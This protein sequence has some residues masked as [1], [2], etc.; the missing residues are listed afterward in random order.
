M[1]K[2]TDSSLGVMA[3]YGVGKF[4]A[5]FLTGAFGAIVFKFYETEIGLAAGYAAIATIIYSLW[6]AINDPLIGYIT[7]R[8][9]PF[10]HKIGRRFP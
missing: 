2:K 9:A 8:K 1:R 10:S 4:L 5:E 3:S 7:N 6:N